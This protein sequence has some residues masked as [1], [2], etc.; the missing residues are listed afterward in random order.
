MDPNPYAL[1]TISQLFQNQK[2]IS[3][4]NQ[5]IN[6]QTYHSHFFAR[7]LNTPQYS[8]LPLLMPSHAR[9][10]IVSAAKETEL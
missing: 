2:H 5:P 4:Q 8:R 7:I 1:A 3:R 9:N 6:H 10:A